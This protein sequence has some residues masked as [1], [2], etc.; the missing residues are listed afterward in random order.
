MGTPPAP[1]AAAPAPQRGGPTGQRS[2][3]NWATK[4][5]WSYARWHGD[6]TPRLTSGGQ[7][8]R[9]PPSPT[10]AGCRLGMPRWKRVRLR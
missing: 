6:L 2:T 9:A 7:Q 8:G 5:I 4:R 1:A 10:Y 3:A